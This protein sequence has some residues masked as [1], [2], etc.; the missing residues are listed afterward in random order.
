M[1][2]SYSDNLTKNKMGNQQETNINLQILI[3]SILRE[4]T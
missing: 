1:R 4:Y 3:S 2:L